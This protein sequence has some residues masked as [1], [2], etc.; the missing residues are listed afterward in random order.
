MG[1]LKYRA[2][3]TTTIPKDMIAKIKLLSKET[4]IPISK[5]AEEAWG[6]LLKKN[7]VKITPPD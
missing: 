6:D 5:L 4:R 7:Y 1:E 3:F 2:Y